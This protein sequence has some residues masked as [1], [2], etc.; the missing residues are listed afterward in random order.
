MKCQ[1]GL[2]VLLFQRLFPREILFLDSRIM[3][4]G[5]FFQD[6]E[7]RTLPAPG[8]TVIAIP[9]KFIEELHRQG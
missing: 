7:I 1:V 9:H 5:Y 8:T 6:L 3:A 4:K 2:E